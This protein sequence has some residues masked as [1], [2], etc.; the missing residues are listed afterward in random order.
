MVKSDGRGRRMS[1]LIQ[2][3]DCAKPLGEI[4]DA[5]LAKGIVYTCSTCNVRKPKNVFDEQIRNIVAQSD[6]LKGMKVGW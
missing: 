5:K 6:F 3:K 4:R 1:R 2:C